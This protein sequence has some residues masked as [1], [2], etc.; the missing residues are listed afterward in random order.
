MKSL[1]LAVIVVL[2]VAA[3]R[4]QAQT[5][6]PTLEDALKTSRETGRPIFALAG[7]ET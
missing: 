2:S 3:G 4:A 1:Q 5:Q 6:L 7:R